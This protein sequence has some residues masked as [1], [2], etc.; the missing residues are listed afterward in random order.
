MAE[1]KSHEL[2]R[3][4]HDNEMINK[5]TMIVREADDVFDKVGGSSRHWVRDCFVP[6]LENAGMQVVKQIKDSEI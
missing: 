6:L 5:L 1:C 4:L 3:V 2:K